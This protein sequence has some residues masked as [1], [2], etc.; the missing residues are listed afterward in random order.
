MSISS[1]CVISTIVEIGVTPSSSDGGN[2]SS[3]DG[4][5]ISSSDDGSHY[6]SLHVAYSTH[7][8]FVGGSDA[9]RDEALLLRVE[10][11]PDGEDEGALTSP[12]IP[13]EP[14]GKGGQSVATC[15]KP[16]ES[17]T[18]TILA[19]PNRKG[20]SRCWNRPRRGGGTKYAMS[21]V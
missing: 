5:N 11:V 12:T 4:G 18:P 9:T 13:V 14:N 16:M 10:R 8:C 21:M 2:I 15:A 1:A 3:S 7:R 19:E 20:D 6:K 17:T